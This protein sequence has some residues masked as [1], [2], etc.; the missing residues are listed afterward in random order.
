MSTIPPVST[1]DDTTSAVEAPSASRTP[2]TVVRARVRHAA[3]PLGSLLLFLVLWQLLAAGGTWSETLVP[4]PAKVWD[5]FIDVSTTH[6][7]VRG[8]NG[9]TLVEHLGVSLRRIALGAGLGIAAGVALGLLMGTVGWVRSLF[10]PWITFLRTLPPLAYFSLLIIWLGIDE[11][12][13]ITLLAVAAFPPVAVS[14]TAAVAAV[15]KSLIEAARALGASR[16]DVVRDVVL[17]SALPETLTGV[18]LAVGVAYS[19]LVA[20]E[21]VNGLP[22]IGGMVKDAANYNNTPVVVVGIIAIG[23]SGLIIDGL[24]LWL[25]RAVVPWRGRA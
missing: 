3:L 6:D 11:E 4:P 1:P 19:S 22:G 18:R 25:E 12:P 2:S 21:L 15:P 10:E 20:A 8:Y 5:A 13:K 16:W 14:T 23:V 9:T 24:L 7:G 17:P